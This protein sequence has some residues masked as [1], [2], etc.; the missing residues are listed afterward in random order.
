MSRT[1]KNGD[2]NLIPGPVFFR[3]ENQEL[4]CRCTT[5]NLGFLTGN[6]EI[7]REIQ[8]VRQ[9]FRMETQILIVIRPWLFDLSV[10]FFADSKKLGPP[11]LKMTNFMLFFNCLATQSYLWNYWT[12]RNG[13]PIN[14]SSFS[15]GKL[16]ENFQKPASKNKI[17]ILGPIKKN[18]ILI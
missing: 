3:L 9:V 12:H 18:K 13:S 7:D 1:H 15:L 6:P 10:C 8:I 11:K 5:L 2:G 4:P 16:S 14:I 17:A